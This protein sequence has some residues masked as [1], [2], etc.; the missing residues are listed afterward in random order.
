MTIT[1]TRSPTGYI[2]TFHGGDL[3]GISAPT[4]HTPVCPINE[5]CATVQARNPEYTVIQGR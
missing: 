3:D 1:I 5:V 2:A 4:P